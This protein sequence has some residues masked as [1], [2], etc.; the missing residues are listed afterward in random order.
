MFYLIIIFVS[1]ILVGLCNLLFNLPVSVN[2]VLAVYFAVILGAVAAFLLDAISAFAIRRM[3][4]KKWY[5]PSRKIFKVSKKERNFYRALKIK[6]WK[7]KIPEL[8]GFTSFHK[9]KLESQSDAEYLERFIVEA[10]YGVVIHIA[11]ALLGALV[12][13]IPFCSSPSIWIPVFAVNFILSLLPV[14]VLRY[15]SYTLQNLHSRC[16]KKD[17]GKETL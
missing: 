12:I 2:D 9:D 11:N 7:D 13:F 3:T 10:N 6:A 1:V 16:V 5:L 4:P 14:A 8:G 15:T 17:A